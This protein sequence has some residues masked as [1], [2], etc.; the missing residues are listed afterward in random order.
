MRTRLLFFIGAALLLAGCSTGQ[1]YYD[2]PPLAFADVD[3]GFKTKT[4]TVNG[5]NVAYIDEG[6]GD[7]TILMVHGLASNAGFWRYNIAGL[8][9]KF[10]VIAV[11]LPG[12]G[13]SDKGAYSYRLTFYADILSGM[14]KQLNVDKVCYDGNSMGGQIG[15]WFAL[16]HPDQ[17]DKL[18]LTDPAGVEHF[19]DGEKDWFRGFFNIPLIRK[20]PEPTIRANLANNLYTFGEKFEWMVEERARTVKTP[21]FDHFAYAVIRSVHAMVDEPT[22]EILGKVKNET[23]VIFGEKDLLIPN[24][25]LHGGYSKDVG[26]KAVREIPNAKLV[27]LQDAGHISMMDQPEAYNNTVTD[28]L[29]R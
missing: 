13:K 4:V 25:Y 14:L 3:Y 8:A 26:E 17:L 5:I 6:R 9:S 20:T 16:R 1:F 23:L 28:F 21:E 10:R 11:D 7:K 22:D 15:I 24:P 27:M 2:T 29:T 12:Y 18:I 19:S